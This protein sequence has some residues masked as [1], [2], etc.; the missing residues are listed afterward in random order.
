MKLGD[1]LDSGVAE[2]LS[3][4]ALMTNVTQQLLP[5]ILSTVHIDAHGLPI[6]RRY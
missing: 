2:R 3:T 6:E 1:V 4:F 5:P